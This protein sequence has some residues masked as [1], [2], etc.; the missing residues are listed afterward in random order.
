MPTMLAIAHTNEHMHAPNIPHP[1]QWPIA[2]PTA[3]PAELSMVAVK[4]TKLGQAIAL[5]HSVLCP[6]AKSSLGS[7][8]FRTARSVCPAL[9]SAAGRSARF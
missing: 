7:L 9:A 2:A 3:M 5:G 4:N 8:G 6:I 1:Y